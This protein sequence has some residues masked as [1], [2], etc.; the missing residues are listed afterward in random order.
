MVMPGI[1]QANSINDQ[2]DSPT[3]P[4]GWEINPGRGSY[5]LTANP[6]YLRYVIDAYHTARFAPADQNYAQSLWLARPFSGKQWILKTAIT[7]NMRPEMPT[8][9]RDTMFFIR[10]PGEGVNWTQLAR[11]HR[12]AGAHD[13]YKWENAMFLFAGTNELPIGLPKLAGP[14]PLDRW[15]IEIERNNDW[16]GIRASNDGN[17]STF[18]YENEYTFSLGLGNDQLIDFSSQ[19]WYGSNNPPGYVDIDFIKVDVVPEPCTLLLLGSGLAGL[20][21]FNS[22]KRLIKKA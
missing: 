12:G 6:G 3:L 7:Y 13:G 21:G 19:G 14:L 18:E 16:V 4:S 11:I 1:V 8:N 15:Y 20:V 5:S 17:D 10:T 22:R 9:N 2:F